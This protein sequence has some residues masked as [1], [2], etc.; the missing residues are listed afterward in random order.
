MPCDHCIPGFIDYGYELPDIR[1]TY[2][3]ELD[4]EEVRVTVS[5]HREYGPCACGSGEYHITGCSYL[6]AGGTTKLL[7]PQNADCRKIIE[8]LWSGYSIRWSDP[9][10]EEYHLRMMEMGIMG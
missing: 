4:F 2:Y 1:D 6:I 8:G 9:Y 5:I 10:D 3:A 7:V